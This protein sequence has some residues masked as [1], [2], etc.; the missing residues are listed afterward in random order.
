M[1]CV[2]D[3]EC[4]WT[5]LPDTKRP[6]P[7]PFLTSNKLVS[8]GLIFFDDLGATSKDY[9][10]FKHTEV[11]DECQA[12]SF[13]ILQEYLNKVDLIVGHNLKFDMTWLYECGLTY[14]GALY[15]T[16][17][18]EY[19]FSK[20]LKRP[21]S[22][23]ESCK[24]YGLDTKSDILGDYRNKGVNT[25]EV[26]LKELIE[27]GEQDLI[28]TKQLYDNQ[29]ELIAS[30][31]DCKYMSKSVK[32]MNDTL[33][34]IIDMERNGINVD[35]EA[36][37][38]VEKQ[39]KEEL[40]QLQTK[41]NQ[42][43][44]NVM[45]HTPINLDSPEHL[46]WVI[47][48]RQVKDK[49]FWKQ[50]FNLGTEMRNSVVKVKHITHMSSNEFNKSVKENT[51]KLKKTEA[52]QCEDCNGAGRIRKKKTDGTDFK[53]ETG[54]KACNGCGYN[55]IPLSKY[56]GFKISPLGAEWAAAG[57]FSTDKITLNELLLGDISDECRE[58]LTALLRMNAVTTYLTTFV[59]GIK[60]NAKGGI[61]HT[62][63]NQCITATGRLSSSNPNFQNLPRAKTFPIRRVIT[64]RFNGGK[65]LSVDFEKF[66][67]T[68]AAIL[69][70]DEVAKKEIIDGVDI[71]IYTMDTLNNAG[72]NI[73]RQDAKSRTFGPL[74]GKTKGNKAEEEYF[75]AFK[76]KY[77][78]I[79]KWHER[80]ESEALHFKQIKSPSGR[81]YA[82]PNVRRLPS[83]NVLNSTQI[84]NY[85]V[86]G[87][88]TADISPIAMIEVNKKIKHLK[89]KLVL[90]V[91]D[92]LTLDI[93]PDEIDICIII[94]KDV[95]N[96]I[97]NYLEEYFQL[98][99]DIPIKGEISIGDN[100]LDKSKIV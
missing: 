75:K 2:L 71:H 85:P 40:T 88:A 96:N 46:S 72:M 90:V 66:E 77:K 8:V 1:K 7:S 24:R 36:L 74:Y 14:S 50:Y 43:V 93:H 5:V 26:P 23:D 31:E 79:T 49:P 12:K 64:S 33:A 57:G 9:L 73:D 89:S 59:E 62:S 29:Q 34:V 94:I 67:F 58:F 81:I 44:I 20:G 35:L 22:L 56:A 48:S 65:I 78:G 3:I 91:H 42:I 19:V 53:K 69:S 76:E 97:N 21:L 63:F 84:K 11:D 99:T 28:I 68:V 70:N 18:A 38:I 82:F 30:D 45:G 87:F 83:G 100:W 51:I 15:D 86:Q 16:M 27:Y 17:I 52:K 25:H 60:K 39:Y 37:D 92:D 98:K 10:I 95:F 41:L 13:K 4:S 80:L 47:Y 61:L 6:N 54:C 55:Y 32:L